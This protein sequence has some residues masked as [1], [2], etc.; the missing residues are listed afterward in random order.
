MSDAGGTAEVND[1]NLTLDDEAAT[2]LPDAGQIADRRLPADQL[3]V[4]ADPY[5]DAR[6]PTPRGPPHSRCSTA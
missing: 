3:G 6:R 2:G 1:L 4:L 5:P